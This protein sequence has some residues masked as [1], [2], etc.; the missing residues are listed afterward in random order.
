[1]TARGVPG[2]EVLAKLK[3]KSGVLSYG[4]ELISD[5]FY[6]PKNQQP[7]PGD[8]LRSLHFDRVESQNK[9]KQPPDKH[10]RHH[11]PKGRTG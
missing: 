11:T 3:I 9:A 8:Q 1:M 10:G 7:K 2:P 6:V 5:G 4:E